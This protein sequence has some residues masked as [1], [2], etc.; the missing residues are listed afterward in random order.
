MTHPTSGTVIGRISRAGDV[1]EP[2]Y[3]C[4]GQRLPACTYSGS[5]DDWSGKT[6]DF[7]SALLPT[8]YITEDV[9]TYLTDDEIESV[10]GSILGIVPNSY[11][12]QYSYPTSRGTMWCWDFKPEVEARPLPLPDPCEGVTCE[13]IC[14][15]ADNYSQVCAKEGVDAGKCVFDELIEANSPDCPGYVPPDLCKDIICEP[16]CFGT[17]N[18]YETVCDEGICVIGPMIE[19][20]SP[21]CPGYV[22]PDPC[23]GVTCEPKCFDNDLHDTVC[24]EG[25]C[26]IGEI[27]EENCSECP[28]YVPPDGDTDDEPDDGSPSG[29]DE[30]PPKSELAIDLSSLFGD[31]KPVHI[32]IAVLA[33]IFLGLLS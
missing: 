19:E 20:N 24:K 21:D 25:V 7:L 26:V 15:N 2:G 32:I 14:I 30:Y 17:S 23:E 3:S 11:V 8:C 27:I 33:M 31:I 12:Y 22:P 6:Q 28:G 18:K 16:E 9:Y 29:D 1:G 13:D 4:W 10:R 5:I